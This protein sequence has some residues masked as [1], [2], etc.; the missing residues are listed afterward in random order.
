MK[1]KKEL[2]L[3]HSNKKVRTR[4]DELLTQNARNVSCF[5]TD[6]IYDLKTQ[7]AFDKA[8][9]DIEEEIKTLDEVFYNVI[10]KQDD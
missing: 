2:G 1:K 8:W 5:G 4:I 9:E 10:S 3:Y 7:K 6:S